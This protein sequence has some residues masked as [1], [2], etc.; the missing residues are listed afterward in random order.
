M[1]VFYNFDWSR[2][3]HAMITRTVNLQSISCPME[4]HI[5]S[6]RGTFKYL[7]GRGLITTVI[8]NSALKS[9]D[10]LLE[11]PEHLYFVCLS[12][13]PSVCLCV[14]VSVCLSICLSHL[15]SAVSAER[16]SNKKSSSV[17]RTLYV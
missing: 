6:L 10:L 1:N 7:I 4:D 15:R 11:G 13:R 9:F 17:P 12:V 5:L 2:L 14:C 8:P 16:T 3:Y